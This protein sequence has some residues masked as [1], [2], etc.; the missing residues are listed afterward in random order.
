MTRCQSIALRAIALMLGATLAPRAG[1]QTGAIEGVA[2]TEGGDAPVQF[3]LVRL[4]RADSSALSP[5]APRGITNAIGRYRLA[6]L[7]PGQYRVQ[8]LRIGYLPVYS[9]PVQVP[10]GATVRLDIRVASQPVLLPPVTVTAERCATREELAQFP[11]LRTLWQQARDGASV[12]TELMNR[13]RFA[14]LIH[15]ET[16]ERKP[17]GTPV[18][19]VDQ[20]PTSDPAFALRNAERR[21]G[22]RLSRGYYGTSNRDGMVG[23]FVPDELDVLHES[24]L[25]QHCLL[26]AV[27]R[28][29]GEFGI[30]FQPLHPRR[31]LLDIGG[32]I[33]LDSAT[34]LAR[35][36]ELQYVDGDDQRGTVRLD[37][38]DVAVAGGTLRMPVGGEIHVRPS[39]KDPTRRSDSAL[40]YTYLGFVEMPRRQ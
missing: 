15:E 17:D 9:E 16:F 39:R 24:F 13:F 11:G 36:I 35:R 26:T 28:G 19:M 23:F 12:R 37:F 29:P 27:Q 18:G 5:A 33:W 22:E 21:R 30:R 34:F 10:A 20:H 14:I 2:R 6:E 31:N 32:T 38:G 40:T 7:S 25:E 8:L 3:A 1:A 4:V